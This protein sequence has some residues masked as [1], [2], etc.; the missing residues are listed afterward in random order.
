MINL[1]EK[2]VNSG[3]QFWR[4]ASIMSWSHC[5]KRGEAEYDGGA[6]CEVTLT[7]FYREQENKTN[8]IARLERTHPSIP[9]VG[10]SHEKTSQ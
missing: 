2:N 7:P 8:N 4:L 3:S 1:E 10:M 6:Q 9:L 5:F